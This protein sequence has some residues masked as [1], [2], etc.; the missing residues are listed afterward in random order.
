MPGPLAAQLAIYLGYVHYGLTGA[1]L[2][3]VAFVLPSFLMVVALGAAY[4]A[5]GGPSWMQAAFYGIGGSV[6]GI[7]TLSTYK[8]TNKTL[9]KDW[10]LWAIFF[11]S[12]GVTVATESEAV[13]LFLFGGARPTVAVQN[14]ARA[15]SCGGRRDCRPCNLSAVAAQ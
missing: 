2:V 3:G 9:G 15:G 14:N 12:A 11:V 1:T 8:L 7:I 5:Y 13:L 4:E 6:I 10:L